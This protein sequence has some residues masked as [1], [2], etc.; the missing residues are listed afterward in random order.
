MHELWRRARARK[1]RER[2]MGTPIVTMCDW[3]FLYSLVTKRIKNKCDSDARP[4]PAVCSGGYC[5][6]S[7]TRGGGGGAFTPNNL[8]LKGESAPVREKRKKKRQYNMYTCTT[9]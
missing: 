6:C 1:E 8:P 9:G 5:Q 4:P 2:Q 7:N 3:A